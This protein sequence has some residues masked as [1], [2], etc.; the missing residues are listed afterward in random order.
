LTKLFATISRWS[1]AFT[2]IAIRPSGEAGM[3][4]LYNACEVSCRHTYADVLL[5]DGNL[6]PFVITSVIV[7]AMLDE[8]TEA[9]IL[10][11]RK[12]NDTGIAALIAGLQNWDRGMRQG[13]TK[14]VAQRDAA[15]AHIFQEILRSNK[16]ADFQ[17]H[18]CSR[19][20][21]GQLGLENLL[22]P[23]VPTTQAD[24]AFAGLRSVVV[25]MIGLFCQLHALPREWVI[26]WKPYTTPSAVNPNY[27]ELCFFVDEM[28][29]RNVPE[30]KTEEDCQKCLVTLT[31][32]PIFGFKEIRER[33]INVG[34]SAKSQVL[35][36]LS[37]H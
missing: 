3:L 7:H 2:T 34:T 22:L 36:R 18:L 5:Q 35:V 11:L 26:S 13:D 33:S 37:S 17:T 1:C 24:E 15:R 21:Q 32:T 20:M 8:I 19:I 6:K 25:K 23:A 28:S 27:S 10:E 14:D 31:I 9:A 16:F 29:A 12:L 30:G 4:A